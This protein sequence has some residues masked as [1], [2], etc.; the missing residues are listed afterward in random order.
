MDK[1]MA[2]KI[3]PLCE[4]G[5]CE[6][7]LTLVGDLVVGGDFQVTADDQVIHTQGSARLGRVA[8]RGGQE[9]VQ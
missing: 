4:S 8:R 5:T 2:S 1:Q 9:A 6:L 7:F 3:K